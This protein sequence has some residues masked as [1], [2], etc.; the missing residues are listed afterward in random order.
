MKIKED[1]IKWNA[2]VQKLSMQVS[3]LA[4]T[5]QN[6]IEEVKVIKEQMTL[7]TNITKEM[8]EALLTLL[9]Q[10]IGD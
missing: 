2:E 6:C 1:L 9:R 5:T 10:Q 8:S 7:L 4:T 3:K